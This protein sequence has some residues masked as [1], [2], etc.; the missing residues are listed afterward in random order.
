ML[1]KKEHTLTSGNVSKLLLVFCAAIFFQC[2]T[3]V[4][5]KDY[6]LSN[7]VSC[8]TFVF[9]VFALTCIVS[10][11]QQRTW[12][13]LSYL[14]A[15]RIPILLVESVLYSLSF[16]CLIQGITT[17]GILHYYSLS[18]VI[19]TFNVLFTIYTLCSKRSKQVLHIQLM[20]SAMCF[21]IGIY[22]LCNNNWMQIIGLISLMMYHWISYIREA[23]YQST[24]RHHK[25]FGRIEPLAMLLAALIVLTLSIFSHLSLNLSSI[26]LPHHNHSY[27]LQE[28]FANDERIFM[29]HSANHDLDVS[30]KITH[31]LRLLLQLDDMRDDIYKQKMAELEQLAA[32]NPHDLSIAYLFWSVLIYIL[33]VLFFV[34]LNNR[35]SYLQNKIYQ[36]VFADKRL[37]NMGINTESS[38]QPH[39][40]ADILKLSTSTAGND[41]DYDN[42]DATTDNTNENAPKWARFIALYQLVSVQCIGIMSYL[43]CSIFYTDRIVDMSCFGALLM[44]VGNECATRTFM[45]LQC[46]SHSQ[47][48]L[49]MLQPRRHRHGQSISHSGGTCSRSLA[50]IAQ[51]IKHIRDTRTSRR[52]FI[53]LSLNFMFM[54]IEFAYGYWSNSLGLISDACHMLFDCVAL[55]IGLLAS[56]LG[57]PHS[58]LFGSKQSMNKYSYGYGKIKV[59]SGFINAIFLVYIGLSVLIESFERIIHPPHIHSDQLLIVSVLGLFVNLVGLFFFHDAHMH[60]HSHSCDHGHDHDHN[61]HGIFLHILADTLGSVGVIISSLLIYFFDLTI[62]DALCSV[63]IAILIF[64]TVYPLIQSTSKILLQ[65]TPPYVLPSLCNDLSNVL[66]SV[67]G[68]IGYREAHF[69][70]NE[71]GNLIGSI[72]IQ[73]DEKC[74]E[75]QLLA[76][77]TDILK[78]RFGFRSEKDLTIQIEKQSYLD[79]CDPIHHSVYSQI[80]P[81]QTTAAA[82]EHNHTHSHHSTCTHHHHHHHHHGD[83]AQ[84]LGDNHSNSSSFI[85]IPLT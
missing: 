39:A 69:W 58:L 84:P 83:E 64:A 47:W 62:F 43:L 1:S 14:N 72:H 28:Q 67:S 17:T 22:L 8:T 61:I 20:A 35:L 30:A 74:D 78:L 60:S 52:L 80:I 42:D 51:F 70:E 56:Y 21:L 44:F 79:K 26:T 77:L 82:N 13:Y 68:I 4:L 66:S 48:L 85:K 59:M 10:I 57:S 16:L 29:H 23:H 7:D 38:A 45:V 11:I 5:V 6:I 73:I 50:H 27:D 65:Q 54:F 76:Q 71:P 18:N 40:M 53:F 25:S 75:Q 9:I 33:F 31:R 55:V 3:L 63:F 2:C 24:L 81:I 34:L 46:S 32:D 15:K 12:K 37:N 36:S 19:Q 41:N 49:R